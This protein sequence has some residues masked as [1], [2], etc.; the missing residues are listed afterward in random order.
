[1]SFE[2]IIKE[3]PFIPI[4]DAIYQSLYRDIITLKIKPG[5]KLNESIL[6]QKMGVSR[7]PVH[8]AIEQLKQDGL[9]TDGTG[10]PQVLPITYEDCCS[11]A[12]ARIGIEGMAAYILAGRIKNR[13]IQKLESVLNQFALLEKEYSFERH[14]EIDDAFHQSIVTFSGNPYLINSYKMMHSRIMRY[15][16]YMLP[17][18]DFKKLCEYNN[19]YSIYFALKNHCVTLAQSEMKASLERLYSVTYFIGDI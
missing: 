10:R 8:T 1:M 9:I 15:R 17:K 4:K 12:E 11:L 18:L 2:S 5:E 7:S 19:H 13:E 16:W 6:A 14:V 3:N